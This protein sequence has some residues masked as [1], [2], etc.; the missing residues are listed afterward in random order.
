MRDVVPQHAM[1]A[2]TTSRSTRS[3]SSSINL[4]KSVKKG[5]SNLLFTSPYEWIIV[6]A[7]CI[8]IRPSSALF[9]GATSLWYIT[10]WCPVKQRFQRAS[11]GIS[12]GLLVLACTAVWDR[13]CYQR[14]VL[15]P[16]NFFAFNLLQGGSEQYGAHPWHWNMSCGVPT[17]LTTLIPLVLVGLYR[18]KE[19]SSQA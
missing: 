4:Q 7:L 18:A 2:A 11:L 13:I 5:G 12:I 8:A 17:V 9:W 14:W 15:V 10:S 6:A 19:F 1:A 16:W 3:S